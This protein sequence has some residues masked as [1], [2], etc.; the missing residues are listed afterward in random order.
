VRPSAAD[1]MIWPPEKDTAAPSPKTLS[2]ASGHHR[3]RRAVNT[4][5]AVAGS[6]VHEYFPPYR[7]QFRIHGSPP[8]FWCCL[9]S[10]A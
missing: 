9:T 10:A 6:A 8:S 5:N 7:R 4:S 1:S 3:P 2:S